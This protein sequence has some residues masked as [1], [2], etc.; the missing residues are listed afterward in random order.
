MAGNC[1]NN[2]SVTPSPPKDGVPQMISRERKGREIRNGRRR[3]MEGD[4]ER[5]TCFGIKPRPRS[6]IK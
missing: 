1:S 3:E 4:E 2:Y 6:L 5:S